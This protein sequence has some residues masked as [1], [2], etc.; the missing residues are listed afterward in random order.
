MQTLPKHSNLYDS[1][2]LQRATSHILS[3]GKIPEVF[4][5][6]A[7]HVFVEICKTLVDWHRYSIHL[8]ILSAE[9]YPLQH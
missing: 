6:I 3:L 4:P 1:F 5:A 9:S 8:S 2:V 7:D